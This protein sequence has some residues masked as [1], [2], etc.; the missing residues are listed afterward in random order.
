MSLT[1]LKS[2]TRNV[3]RQLLRQDS[4][5]YENHRQSSWMTK[6]DLVNTLRTVARSA[7][8]DFMEALAAGAHVSMIGEFGSGFYLLT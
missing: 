4:L 5:T 3:L 7:T 1:D 8:K 6:A 2:A